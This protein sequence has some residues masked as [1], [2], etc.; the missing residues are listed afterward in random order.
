MPD[1]I[2][3]GDSR[4]LL[5]IVLPAA[6]R[7]DLKSVKRFIR[8][9]VNWLYRVGPHGRTMLWEA[10]YKNR[11][12]TVRFLIENGADVNALATYYTP[13]IVDLCPYAVARRAGNDE[14]MQLLAKSGALFDIHS[15][16]Y[17][18]DNEKVE[19]FLAKQPDAANATPNIYEGTPVEVADVLF[20]KK[21][22][23]AVNR[24]EKETNSC[25]KEKTLNAFY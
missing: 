9:D 12:D 14:L 6:A 13:L 18:G 17:F 21:L 3:K 23:A 4:D 11:I 2:L 16:A 22:Q 19:E 7:G 20:N 24:I 1:T 5:R 8:S 15:A 25:R 10:A